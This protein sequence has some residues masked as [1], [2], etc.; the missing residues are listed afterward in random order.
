MFHFY[1]PWKRQ[2]I[3]VFL[4]SLEVYRNGALGYIVLIWRLLIYVFGLFLSKIHVPVAE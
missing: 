4:I 1:N 3:F 2:K